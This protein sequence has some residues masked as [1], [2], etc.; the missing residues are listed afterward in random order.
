M[1]NGQ[2]IECLKLVIQ[3]QPGQASLQWRL[4]V[5]ATGAAQLGSINTCQL[6]KLSRRIYPILK[7]AQELE[8]AQS[9]HW[10]LPELNPELLLCRY[11]VQCYGL[12]DEGIAASFHTRYTLH[13]RP[14]DFGILTVFPAGFRLSHLHFYPLIK[15]ALT[16]FARSSPELAGTTAE[17]SL[18]HLLFNVLDVGDQPYDYYLTQPGMTTHRRNHGDT[19]H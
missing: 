6:R 17:P 1:S 7:K 4:Q 16:Y 10:S 14:T 18:W 9:H 11:Q 13:D 12:G 15:I 3:R 19:G 8:P 2:Q 5:P